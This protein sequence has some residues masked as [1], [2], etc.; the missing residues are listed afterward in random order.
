MINK[1]K[2]PTENLLSNGILIK[3]STIL[4]KPNKSSDKSHKLIKYYQIKKK[5]KLTISMD[6][7]DLNS[8]IPHHHLEAINSTFMM[9][10]IFLNTFLKKIHSKMTFS[11]DSLVIKKQKNKL[12]L[13]QEVDVLVHLMVILS[14]QVGLVVD[15]VV[16]VV[17]EVDCLELIQCLMMM[18]FFRIRGVNL[19]LDVHHHLQQT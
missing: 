16:L 11:V 3:T 18:I 14:F 6:I 17:L 10:K 19:T 15:L 4:I 7:K 5:E 13:K 12:L 1:S 8:K 9:L 2:K